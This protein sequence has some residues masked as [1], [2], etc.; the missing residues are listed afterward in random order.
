MILQQNIELQELT[1]LIETLPIE[2][3]DGKVHLSQFLQ[4]GVPLLRSLTRKSDDGELA[5]S[6]D[7]CLTMQFAI[8]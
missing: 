1:A 4:H 3:V 8:L 5:S 2:T 7:V 6:P